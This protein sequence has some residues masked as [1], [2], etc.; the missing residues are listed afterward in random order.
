M[1]LL[2]QSDPDSAALVGTDPAMPRVMEMEIPTLWESNTQRL[3]SRG[4]SSQKAERALQ[5]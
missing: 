4:E 2:G 5:K 1:S 3:L